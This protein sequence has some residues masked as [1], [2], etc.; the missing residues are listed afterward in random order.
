MYLLDLSGI[1]Y[2]VRNNPVYISR[3]LSA[4]VSYLSV[5]PPYTLDHHT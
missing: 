1:S 5:P 3:A 4:V 2:K